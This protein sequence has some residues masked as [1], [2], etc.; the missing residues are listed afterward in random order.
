MG[1]LPVERMKRWRQNCAWFR[2]TRRRIIL[3]W[4]GRDIGGGRAWGRRKGSF[5]AEECLCVLASMT[6]GPLFG[7]ERS[8][9][10]EWSWCCHCH[11][12]AA[13]PARVPSC[14]PFIQA[15]PDSF[16]ASQL[17]PARQPTSLQCLW[18]KSAIPGWGQN[19][20]A[21]G[22]IEWRRVTGSLFLNQVTLIVS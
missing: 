19:E 12:C 4:H 21:V 22:R 15:D 1:N 16:W 10:M 7:W 5:W 8:G 6:F 2:Q 11:A 14:T 13:A 3:C 9:L 20:I 17:M 18:S